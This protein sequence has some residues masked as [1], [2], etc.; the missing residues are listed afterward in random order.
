[1]MPFFTSRLPLFALFLPLLTGQTT[2]PQTPPAVDP[3]PQYRMQQGDVVDVRF[4]YN[5]ELNEGS[6]I[7]RPDGRIS[8]QLVGD[9]MLAG[10]T[11]EEVR[12]DLEAA[13]SSQ[14]KT[15]RISIQIRGFSAQKAYVSGEV[16]RPGTVS[17]AASAT[18]LTALGEAGGISLRGD[19]NRVVLIRR[20]PDGLPG[21]QELKLFSYGKPTP[22]A[23]LPL[24]PHFRFEPRVRI[25]RMLV[26][27]N[28]H[29]GLKAAKTPAE[30]S[31]QWVTNKTS[32]FSSRSTA[33]SRSTSRDRALL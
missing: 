13:Y 28:I 4:F 15:P 21:K 32:P 17:L 3:D 2:P 27:I 22:A 14:L 23:M 10:R 8:L 31:T 19:R 7:I 5:P 30:D 1:M 6:V 20:L 18:V 26:R 33:F 9:V 29:R 25:S 24:N 12:K 11:V 16:L